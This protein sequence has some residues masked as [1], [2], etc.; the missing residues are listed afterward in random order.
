MS[1][2]QHEEN[3]VEETKPK[4]TNKV[5]KLVISLWLVSMLALLGPSLLI[6]AVSIDFMG[7]FGGLP[8]YEV[9]ENPK[10]NLASEIYSSDGKILGHYYRTKRSEVDYEEL[11]P[12]ITNALVATEDK[13]FFEHSGVSLPAMF[14]VGIK[15]LL[16]GQ[17]KGGGSTVS[18]QLAKNLFKTREAYK[19]KLSNVPKLGMLIV[20]IKEWIVSVQLERSYTKKEIMAMYLNTVFF[21]NNAFGI[22][23][24]AQTFFNKNQKDLKL[25]EAAV[26]VGLVQAPSRLNPRRHPERAKVRRNVVLGQMQKYNKIT[27][28][29]ADSVK[30][31]ELVLDYKIK[32][33][34]YGLATYF[35]S[36]ISD[37]LV[38]WAKENDYDLWSAGLK[39][40]TTIDSRMQEHAEKAVKT[41][42]KSLQAKFEQ[43]W[44]NKNPWIDEQG[45]E[46]KNFLMKEV[47]RTKTYKLYNKKFNGDQEQVIQALSIP[48][49]MRVF[50]WDGEIDTVMSTLDS[51]RYYK[52]FL[53]TGFMAMDPNTGHIKS[54]V[55]GINHKYF[56][57]DHVKKSKRQPGSTFKPIVYAAAI[58]NGY[59][60]CTLAEDVPVS[61]PIKGQDSWVPQNANGKFTGQKMTLRQAMSRSVNSITAWVMSKIGPRT[62]VDYAKSLGVTSKMAAVPA[63]CLG[64]SEV[65]IYEMVGAYS[66]FVN[67]GVYIEPSFILRIEDKNGNVIQDFPAKKRQVLNEETAY[68]MTYMLRG[69][70][71]EAGGTASRLPMSL[72]KNNEIGG[73]TGTTQNGS[74]GWFIGVTKD[75][76]AGVWTGGDSRSIRFRSWVDGQGARTAL[77]AW[78][79]FM[80]NVYA[81]S[82]L[83]YTKGKFS[84]PEK[85]NRVLDCEV[86]ENKRMQVLQDTSLVEEE[87]HPELDDLND[88]DIL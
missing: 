65:S 1:E 74:D 66:T 76:V 19:G 62:V 73:K 38:K 51:L 9:L 46:I 86:I 20:K 28:Q 37:F 6:Y 41:H 47:K 14:R 17:N 83:N 10:S 54:W 49:K 59:S 84:R 82:T 18:Q 24:A 29:V 70:A 53:Q 45:R 30:K 43:R 42:M 36:S 21:G 40:Y 75:L 80:T 55:G 68:L 26:L 33:H 44:G 79:N 39:I 56:K 12:Y 32:N 50:S 71:E 34:N 88:A 85:L 81:D 3:K 35:R 77:P 67:K 25:E 23:S 13:D 48:K 57:Y 58:D 22:E 31:T 7:L 87:Y 2:N 52:R 8:S 27:K 78:R 5:K 11:S 4:K 15:S 16:L 72:R 61:F 69:T 63:L 64:V 60:P